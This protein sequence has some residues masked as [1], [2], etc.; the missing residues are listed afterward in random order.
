[1]CLLVQLLWHVFTEATV[2]ACVYWG[3]CCVMYL[4]RRLLWH[5]FTGVTVVSCVY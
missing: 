5:V 3:R 4:L 1:M 2:V